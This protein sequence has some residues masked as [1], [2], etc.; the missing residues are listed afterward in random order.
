M[1]S[2]G[3][4]SVLYSF[5]LP[6]RSSLCLYFVV[7][8][9]ELMRIPCQLCAQHVPESSRSE[10]QTTLLGL[11]RT[12]KTVALSV[13]IRFDRLSNAV[14]SPG[15]VGNYSTDF[16]MLSPIYFSVLEGQNLSMCRKS[17]R[18]RHLSVEIRFDRLS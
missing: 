3:W 8:L 5:S 12:L 11:P 15:L 16:I 9:S 4:L 18:G 10:D 2:H 14:S 17:G 6:C 7:H 13:E 1:T